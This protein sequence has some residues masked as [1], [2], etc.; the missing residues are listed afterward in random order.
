MGVDQGNVVLPL[1]RIW[2]T[3]RGLPSGLAEHRNRGGLPCYLCDPV[4]CI[5]FPEPV[6]TKLGKVS[7]SLFCGLKL[8][9]C[10]FPVESLPSQELDEDQGERQRRQNGGP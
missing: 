2:V 9:E 7:E 5:G 8:D 3:S 6:G 1:R 10:P 4:I